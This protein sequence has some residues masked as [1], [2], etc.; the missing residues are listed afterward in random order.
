MRYTSNNYTQL[1][2]YLDL[3]AKIGFIE[4]N[5]GQG[6]VLYRASEKGLAFLRQYNILRDMLIG[7]YPRNE[8]INAIQPYTAT[9]LV[10]RLMKRT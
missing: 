4:V 8:P 5:I 1:K 2:K 3:L 10:T 9:P 6:K 7:V